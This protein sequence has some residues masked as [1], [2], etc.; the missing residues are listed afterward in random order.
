MKSTS[1]LRLLAATIFGALG[2]AT[3]APWIGAPW[4]GSEAPSQEQTSGSL[5]ASIA[6]AQRPAETR[7][8]A[9]ESRRGTYDRRSTYQDV[10]PYGQGGGRSDDRLRRDDR[11]QGGYAN[12]P[13]R[14]DANPI[15]LDLTPEEQANIRVYEV[16]NHSV[17]NIT[18]STVQY[19]RFWMVAQEGHGSGS[20]SVIDKQGHILTN[21]HVI[22]NAQ[23]IQVTLASGETYEAELVGSD[24]AYDMAVIKIDAPEEELF[25]I[26]LGRSNNLR[27]G[28]RAYALGNPFGLEGTLTTGIISS[29]NRALP[30]RQ[31][32][33]PMTGMIQ[34]DAAMNPGNS[35]GPLLDTSARMVGMNVA[36]A[37][38]T[39]QNTGVGFAIPVDRVRR[40]LSDLIEHG[41][42]IR[43]YHGIVT[44]ME[45]P[46]GLKIVRLSNGGPAEEA[47]LK[48]F[49]IIKRQRRQ[50]NVIFIETVPDKDSADHIIAIDG[51]PVRSH[52]DFLDIMDRHKPGDEVQITILRQGRSMDVSL[53]LGAA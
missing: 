28:Q 37:T 11:R 6:E 21:N 15:P 49:R 22:D 4:I 31:G 29:L 46:N 51:R 33:V 32:D 45:T 34:T 38:K 14:Q 24:E 8:P 26:E 1:K 13:R 44:L 53:T 42:I 2:Y 36:I 12:A 39:G 35:G 5:F 3:M 25:P 9:A 43:A 47:G 16:A 48:G 50:G 52:T 19:D 10:R 17:V 27:V 40:T 41:K 23:G 7:P 20:G 30:S 18:T